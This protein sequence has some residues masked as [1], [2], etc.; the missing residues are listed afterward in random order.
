MQHKK[1][2]SA[3]HYQWF[4]VTANLVMIAV[5]FLANNGLAFWDDFTYLNFA[6]QI[7]EGSFELGTNHFTSRVALLYPTAWVI[8]LLGI[9]EWTITLYPLLCGLII[10]NLTL[11]LGHLYHHWLGVLAATILVCDYHII[12]FITHLFPE[13]P[14]AL[15]IFMALVAYDRVNRRE[16]DHRLAAL[17]TA[18]ALFLAYLT[19]MTV[20][21]IV[22]L[23]LY[24]FFNDYKRRQTNKSY[25]MITLVLLI[26]FVVANGFWYQEVYGDFFY[27]FKNIS[28]NHEASAKTFFDKDNLTLLKRLTYLPLLGFLRGG[29]FVPLL[30]CLPALLATRRKHWRLESPEHL[31]RVSV[32]MVLVTWWFMSTNW[33]YYS[34]M[35]VDTRHITFLIPLMLMAGGFYWIET[36]LLSAIR[37]TRAKFLLAILLVIPAYKVSSSGERNFRELKEAV[38]HNLRPETGRVRVFTDG[39]TSYG[40]PYFYNFQATDHNYVW[41]SELNGAAPLAGDYLLLNPAFLNDRYHDHENLEALKVMAR[42]SGL[43]LKP[44][45]NGKVQLW[46]WVEE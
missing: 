18:T 6:R 4:V 1:F 10:L 33:R 44:L 30:F 29:F 12:T 20:I 38:E 16:G 8:E 28:N 5:W 11:W 22:P 42:E 46:R 2:F 32:I 26:F 24:L 34:P 15:F 25:W 13:M 31:W 36:H 14:M 39:L 41:F 43:E 37:Y 7:N 21:L 9:N 40:Y 3:R 23:F 35:P 19:K 45:R 17:I 27:R